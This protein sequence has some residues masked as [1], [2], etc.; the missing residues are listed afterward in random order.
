[1]FSFYSLGRSRVLDSGKNS[2]LV[3]RSAACDTRGGWLSRSIRPKNS[4]NERDSDE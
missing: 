4:E 1:M 2:L 3:Q